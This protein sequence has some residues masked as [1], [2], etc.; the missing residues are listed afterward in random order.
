MNAAFYIDDAKRSELVTLDSRNAEVIRP[1]ILG[2]DCK[3]WAPMRGRQWQIFTPIGVDIRRY[4]SILDHLRLWQP[5]L[6]KRWDKGNHWWELRA[7]DFYDAFEQCKIVYPQIMVEPNFALDEAGALTNQKCFIIASAERY[8]L[9]VLNSATVWRLILQNSPGL[10]G[11]YAEPR[12]DFILSLTIPSASDSDR[13][14]IAALV[15]KCIDAKGVD[16]AA[17]EKAID[18]QVAG[19]YGL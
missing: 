4:P 11:G 18:E 19:L 14:A 7:C 6:E 8:L 12:K 9:G 1:L 5:Q 13:T 17:W 16:C 15:Q 3:R 10:R 2:R